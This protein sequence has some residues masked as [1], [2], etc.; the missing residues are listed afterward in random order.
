MTLFHSRHIGPNNQ[1]MDDMLQALQVKSLTE[2][3]AKVV[4]NDIK[5]SI[6]EFPALSEYAYINKLK[7]SALKNKVF[8]SYIGCGYNPTIVPPVIQRN[9]FENPGWYT[10]YTPYQSEISQGRLE[11]LLNFQ[12]LISDLTGLAIA[13]AS[14]LDEA[15]AAAEAM[16]MSFRIANR[17]KESRNT[18]FV[19]KDVFP[20][21]LAVLEGRAEPLG[22]EL[23]IGD[24][25]STEFDQ[26]LFGALYQTPNQY[27][28]LLDVENII[29]RAKE[30]N[31]FVTVVTDPMAL[32]LLKS[33]G[34]MGADCVVGSAQRFGVP[35]GF[36]GP[37]AGFFATREEFQRFVPGRIIG[38]SKD[39]T[40]RAAFRMALQTREQHIRREKATS[41]I[42]TAQALLAIM[43]GM[44]A[45]YHGPQGLDDIASQ[46]HRQ[47]L[48]LL[49]KLSELGFR[50]INTSFFDTLYFGMDSEM[51]EKI[52]ESALQ[53]GVNF[54]FFNDHALSI[55]LHEA[56][57]TQ[58]IDEIVSIFK[59]VKPS[60]KKITLED[61]EPIPLH[62]RRKKEILTHPVFNEHQ[63]ETK[64]MRYIK[65]LEK[66]DLSLTTSMIPLGSCTMKLNASVELMP[67]SWPEFSEIH[68]FAPREQTQG[69]QEIFKEL[70]AD[71]GEITGLP[72]VSLQ[73]NSGAQGELAGLLVIRAYHH[74]Q[75]EK[76]RNKVL[77]PTSAHG[78]NPASATM[79]GLEVVLVKC[80]KRGNI[81]L[82]DLHDKASANSES[83]TALM[84][85][86]PSTHGVFEK[87][88]R[89]IC[90]IIHDNGGQIYMDGANM[91]AQ[92]GLTKPA[93]IGADVC[94][95]NLHKTFSI[96]HG[97]GGPGAGPIC[98]AK[99]LI[100]YLPGHPFSNFYNHKHIK[101]V[102]AAPFGSASILIISHAYIKLMGSK[103]LEKASQVAILNSNYIK[104]RLE[105]A[106]PVLYT[107]PDGW[108]A[109]E[110]I[111]D[112]RPM[113]KYNIEAEDVAKRLM[114]YG[115]H[116]PTVSWPVLGTMMIEPTESESQ[117][118]LDRFCEAMLSIRHEIENIESGVWSEKHN[119][120]K[121]APHTAF[122]LTQADWPFPYDRKTAVYPLLFIM[123]NKF[124]PPV[125]RVD[126]TYGDRNLICICPPVESYDRD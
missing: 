111:I 96:P 115:F 78:T 11:A 61:F 94:H 106:F 52:S 49:T 97:G 124:W 5:S 24:T 101:P 45:V 76:Q 110:M 89:K 121:N 55:S 123:E 27:G 15:T 20:Q 50:Q 75:G 48:T 1:Q 90:K 67:V 83:L 23:K 98:V 7:K 12:T 58:D 99:H 16:A 118:E 109:H 26:S 33:P 6:K 53:H 47:T 10:Q 68:P 28:T 92:V 74:D 46:I 62:W 34:E 69:Y 120:L 122:E 100:P 60:F 95:L 22:I 35:M 79:A 36:G 126:N 59:S 116:S 29:Q 64:M 105:K 17:G 85:T 86:Y 91:N 119:P 18:F 114:D 40:G 63:S 44:Y 107:D 72:G 73:P 88:V 41:N 70:E 39:K 65:K 104:K 4:P 71:L 82:D 84:L 80:D 77:I 21:T 103:G 25:D 81:D 13:N 112:L 31:I 43:A 38:V 87:N 56:T 66:R 9:I 51:I 108:V 2:L 3:A 93:M 32:V 42:C 57:T 30:H 19:H 125:N 117:D 54:R 113:K 102:A 37:H 14:L 8:K